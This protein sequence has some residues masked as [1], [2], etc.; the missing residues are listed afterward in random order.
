MWNNAWLSGHLDDRCCLGTGWTQMRVLKD[1]EIPA[2]VFSYA[3]V[4]I[5]F[6]FTPYMGP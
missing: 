5:N 6:Q 2:S 3:L 4:H 1:T